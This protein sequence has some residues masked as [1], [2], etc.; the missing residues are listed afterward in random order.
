MLGISFFI[1]IDETH[2]MYKGDGKQ[3]VVTQHAIFSGRL[4]WDHDSAMHIPFPN[5]ILAQDRQ[6]SCPSP[7][8]LKDPSNDDSST[9]YQNTV[10]PYFSAPGKLESNTAA[11]IHADNIIISSTHHLSAKEFLSQLSLS[12]FHVRAYGA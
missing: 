12:R 11:T 10:P 1:R 6:H 5:F 8:W 9:I 4:S 2:T 3:K 7:K